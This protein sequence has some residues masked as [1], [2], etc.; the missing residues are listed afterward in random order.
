MVK[1]LLMLEKIDESRTGISLIDKMVAKV[2]NSSSTVQAKMANEFVE[3]LW[4]GIDDTIALQLISNLVK[5][6]DAVL[7]KFRETAAVLPGI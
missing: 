4:D 6:E 1:L 3:F 2:G 7:L 5:V